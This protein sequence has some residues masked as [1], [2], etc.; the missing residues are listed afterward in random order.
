M[1]SLC[2]SATPFEKIYYIDKL[3]R[4]N[5][6]IYRIFKVIIEW[7]EIHWST[8]NGMLKKDN[9]SARNE[10]THM[11]K[12]RRINCKRSNVWLT[13]LTVTFE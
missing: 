8:S 5:M 2:D 12:K 3:E 10:H 7:P 11:Q 13:P 4:T 1:G 9:R 6:Y